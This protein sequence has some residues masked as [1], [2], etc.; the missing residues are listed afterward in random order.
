[1]NNNNDKTTHSFTTGGVPCDGA[2]CPIGRRVALGSFVSF[3]GKALERKHGPYIVGLYWERAGD[4]ALDSM[5]SAVGGDRAAAF[6]T[7]SRCYARSEE[8]SA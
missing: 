6:A 4:A 5:H 3:V 8:H 7:A 1:M 2:T